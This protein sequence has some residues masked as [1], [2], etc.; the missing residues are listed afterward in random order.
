MIDIFFNSH[1]KVFIE[2][3]SAI[4]IYGDALDVLSRMKDNSINLIFADPPYNIGKDFGNKTIKFSKFEYIEWCKKW[5]SECYRVLH[6]TGTFYF[7]AA[8]Q[9]MPYLDVFASENFFIL[10]RIIWSYD[11]SGVQTKRKFGSMYE[12]IIMIVKNK[13]KYTFNADQI[14]VEA[15]TGASRKLIDYRKSPPQ[16]YNSRKVPGNVWNFHRVRYRMPEYENHPSQKPESLLTRIIKASSNEGDTVFDPF[17]GSFSTGSVAIKL[18]RNAISCDNNYEFYKIG[19][20]R[21]G[22]ST[23]L[24]G[25]IL[26]RN[27]SR[28]TNNKSK[29]DHFENPSL[30]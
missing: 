10:S 24:D 30:F 8:T 16:L 9:Y 25:E 26:E 2:S 19:I 22:I 17:G 27:L 3:E 6:P 23:K 5:I 11:S 4:A 21:M 29:K 18:N 13:N 15:K 14:E 1:P 20:R 28:K 7:M 12:P